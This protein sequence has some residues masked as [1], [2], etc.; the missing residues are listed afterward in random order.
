MANYYR[1]TGAIAG[2]QI[3]LYAIY[4]DRIGNL[5]DTDDLPEIYMYSPSIEDSL[6]DEEIEAE[7]Y[8]SA[9]FGPLTATRISTGYYKLVYTIP[10]GAEEGVWRDVW[11]AEIDSVVSAE[12]LS[13][14]V[15]PTPTIDAQVISNNTM[16]II[17]LSK[18]I[19]NVDADATLEEDLKLYFTTIYSPLYASPDL[20]RAEVGRWID[21]LP[22]D[23]VALMIHWSSKEAD[24]INGATPTNPG[25]YRFARTRFVVFDT[26]LRCILMPGGGAV[27]AAESAG[28]GK[29]QLGEFMV[30]AGSGVAAELAP[31][32]LNWLREQREEWW[33]VV[34]AGGLIVPGM[35][36]PMATAKKGSM[37][38]DR[39]II[40]R[41]WEDPQETNYPVPTTNGAYDSYDPYGRLR[42]RRR[43]GFEEKK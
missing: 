1:Q 9:S 24:F 8:A 39:K 42:R 43:F 37:S 17:E 29:K 36:I 13:W 41:I 10:S 11:V 35:S 32:T 38:P 31:A 15:L 18:D 3:T 6:I 34:N 23:T 26:A 28:G 16:I 14:E 30:Q 5:V 25:N 33:R 7:T 22:D 4:V 19:A 12:L 21:H 20:V 27:T 40:A 2:A